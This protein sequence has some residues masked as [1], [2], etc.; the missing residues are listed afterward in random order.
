MIEAL[1]MPSK[2]TIPRI[3]QM[4]REYNVPTMMSMARTGRIKINSVIR[5]KVLKVDVAGVEGKE[6]HMWGAEIARGAATG[7]HSHPTPRF[8]YVMQ[9]SVTVEIDGRPPQVFKAGDG[10]QEAPDVPHNFR[11]ASD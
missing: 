2:M 1:K 6:A 9:G 7:T 5:A 8:V 11:N 10:F 4:L 3:S